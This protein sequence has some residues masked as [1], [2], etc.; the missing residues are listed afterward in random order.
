M[1]SANGVSNNG[2][3]VTYLPCD[4]DYEPRPVIDIVSSKPQ[5][6]WRDQLAPVTWSMTYIDSSNIS[7]SVTLRGDTEEE[8]L[9]MVKP[10]VAGIRKAKAKAKEAGSAT[11]TTAVPEPDSD[12]PPCKIHGIPMQRRVSRRTQGI[13][14][15]HKLP[16]GDLCFGREKA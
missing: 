15:S 7:H 8:V 12:V 3:H 9:D 13:Y 14:F 6:K 4:S 11:E 10:L 1:V 5:P 2:H 16:N